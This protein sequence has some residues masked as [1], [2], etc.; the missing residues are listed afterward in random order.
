MTGGF[1]KE[2]EKQKLKGVPIPNWI[3]QL[4]YTIKG[5]VTEHDIEGALKKGTK[6]L[7]GDLNF[8]VLMFKNK[9]GRFTYNL[10]HTDSET[11]GTISI[12]FCLNKL[13]VAHVV[14]AAML[15]DRCSVYKAHFKVKL[16]ENAQKEM[17]DKLYT[18]TLKLYNTVFEESSVLNLNLIEK[19][20]QDLTKVEFSQHPGHLFTGK[21]FKDSNMAY[22]VEGKGDLMHLGKIGLFNIITTNGAA[23][24]DNFFELIKD[25]TLT[26]LTDNDRGGALIKESIFKKIKDFYIV[27]IPHNDTFETID[28]KILFTSLENKTLYSTTRAE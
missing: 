24:P 15:V 7:L 2:K 28:K 21:T 27:D 13:E 18:L 12:P 14:A 16:V 11:K 8:E 23:I 19:L 3:A 9:V 4:E 17:A 5:L 22:V 20:E 25:K 26:V 10:N 6:H 1:K